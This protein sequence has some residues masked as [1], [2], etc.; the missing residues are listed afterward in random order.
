MYL[1]CSR[2]VGILIVMKDVVRRI[3][4]MEH[5][6]YTPRAKDFILEIV[7]SLFIMG[8]LATVRMVT[9]V[10]DL[11]QYAMPSGPRCER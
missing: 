8:P 7:A 5:F 4:R 3:E 9:T 10:D 2:S 6:N 11:E 1:S